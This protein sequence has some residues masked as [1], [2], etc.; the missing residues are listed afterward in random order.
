MKKIIFLILVIFIIGCVKE[1]EISQEETSLKEVQEL[2]QQT[3]VQET[4]E[5]QTPVQEVQEQ[6]VQIPN[7][8]EERLNEILENEC[9][10][11]NA[12]NGNCVPSLEGCNPETQ[13]IANG[14]KGCKD[15][16]VCCV[17]KP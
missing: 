7:E 16:E 10:H 15:S 1:V 3:S 17:P 5:Q 8:A 6:E 11:P 4:Q 9:E 2:E 14:V 13:L 12:L